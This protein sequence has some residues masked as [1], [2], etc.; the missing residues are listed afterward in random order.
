[1][2]KEIAPLTTTEIAALSGVDGS[3]IQP[4]L[5]AAMTGRLRDLRL[6]ERREWPDGPLWRTS[7]GERRLR[8][9][10]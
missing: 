10:M 3:R 6:I 8:E 5:S 1:M 2:A 4:K 9:G 7:R